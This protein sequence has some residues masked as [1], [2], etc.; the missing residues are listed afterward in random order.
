VERDCLEKEKLRAEI[1]KLTTEIPE[2]KPW[3]KI[4]LENLAPLAGFATFVWAAFT[5]FREERQKRQQRRS[6]A[7]QAT[8]EVLSGESSRARAAASASILLFADEKYGERVIDVILSQLRVELDEKSQRILIDSFSKA[9]GDLNIPLHI[10]AHAANLSHGRLGGSKVTAVDFT[11]C[12]LEGTTITGWNLS[13]ASF[14]DAIGDTCRF[15]GCTMTE[16]EFSMTELLATN[17]RSF[18]FAD[19]KLQ[20]T[21]FRNCKFLNSFAGRNQLDDVLFENC[22]FTETD[23]SQADL[24]RAHF[25]NVGY[26]DFNTARTLRLEGGNPVGFTM[27]DASRRVVIE[28]LGT[29][30]EAT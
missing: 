9:I 13:K 22:S 28:K 30:K 21:I 20:R 2:K 18:V 8:V 25:Q 5:Y 1:G 29:T 15:Q 23:F 19:C 10:D 24:T 26:M 17:R 27:D 3:W 7:F 11:E 6:E 14:Q 16:A 12:N 4:W